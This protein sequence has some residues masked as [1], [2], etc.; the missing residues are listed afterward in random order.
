MTKEMKMLVY[1]AKM[2]GC[3]LFV[4]DKIT[5]I[6]YNTHG[7]VDK[8]YHYDHDETDVAARIQNRL[9][10][11]A[12]PLRKKWGAEFHELSP[13]AFSL[14]YSITIGDYSATLIE[15]TNPRGEV[16]KEEVKL[17]ECPFSSTGLHRMSEYIGNIFLSDLATDDSNDER[18]EEE[19]NIMEIDL[20]TELANVI[21]I[22]YYRM[23]AKEQQD[24]KENADP[25][26]VGV[27]MQAL[28]ISASN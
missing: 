1:Q 18:K 22:M 7:G 23:S 11:V 9:N 10:E 4:G 25:K 8:K 24:L 20:S 14:G 16:N 26:V 17:L 13:V 2:V 28:Q 5:L 19:E 12:K 6:T 3:N 27:I 21:A 15:T